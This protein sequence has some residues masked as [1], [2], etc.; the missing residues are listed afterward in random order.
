MFLKQ[1]THCFWTL[2]T[3]HHSI[4]ICSRSM[5]FQLFLTMTHG[6]TKMLKTILQLCSCAAVQSLGSICER[7]CWRKICVWQWQWAS[8]IE[9]SA[10]QCWIL[11]WWHWSSCH[12]EQSSRCCSFPQWSSCSIHRRRIADMCSSQQPPFKVCC[13]R[14]HSVCM[15][16]SLCCIECKSR[17]SCDP[18]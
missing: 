12:L 7:K 11:S 16:W 8:A 6:M 4:E 14:S 2:M 10:E 17:S 3:D 18:A 1:T 5:A 9:E 15:A 13:L